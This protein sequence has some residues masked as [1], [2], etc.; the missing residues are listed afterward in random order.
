MKQ[1]SYSQDKSG[2]KR[3]FWGISGGKWK[4]TQNQQTFPRLQKFIFSRLATQFLNFLNFWNLA[5]CTKFYCMYLNCI[6]ECKCNMFHCI[7]SLCW[8][9][10]W[11]QTT[12]HLMNIALRCNYKSLLLHQNHFA[13]WHDFFDAAILN[14]WK[15]N[16]KLPMNFRGNIQSGWNLARR[17]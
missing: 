15:N 2:K 1:G 4:V 16:L 5:S 9:H 3:R 7:Y 13:A 14:R 17:N 11:C 12:Y 6:R 10:F 8:T